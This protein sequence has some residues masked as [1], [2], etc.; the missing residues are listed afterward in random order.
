MEENQKKMVKLIS[1]IAL[2]AIVVIVAFTTVAP[3]EGG[4]RFAGTFWSLVPPLVAII[5]ALITREV[6][7]S[8]FVGIAIGALFLADGDLLQTLQN[9]VGFTYDDA[10]GCFVT[11]DYGFLN[12]LSSTWNAGILMFLVVLG[13][14]GVIMYA[15]GG[16]RAF[17][18]WAEKHIKGPRSAQAYTFG[19]G[20]I[21]FIDDYF[22]CL[23][24]GTTMRS[25]TDK[26]K[27]SRAKLAY[28]IDSTAAPICII[29]PISSW[30]AAV[31]GSLP[32]TFTAMSGFDIFLQS[33]PYNFYAIF[34]IV[35]I[36]V[37]IAF[38]FDFGPM[39]IHE[40]NAREKG[41]LYTTSERPY[42]GVEE[43]EFNPKGKLIDL[44]IPI[45]LF[46]VPISIVMMIYTGGFFKGVPFVDAFSGADASLA[47]A[48][49]SVLSLLLTVGYFSIRRTVAFKDMMLSLPKGFSNMVYA[50]LILV[51][52]WTMCSITSGLDSDTFVKEALAGTTIQNLLP[53]AFM[54]VACFIAFSTGTSWGTFGILIPIVCA[55]F[56]EGG[57][58]FVV[59]VSASLAGAVFGDHCSPVSDTTIL[60][61]A[62]AQCD[63]LNHVSTQAP[64]AIL[65]AAIS[66]VFFL[67]AGFWQSYIV[68]AIG[69]VAMVAILFLIKK[70]ED[71]G[72]SF[73][74][75]SK[76][77]R[78]V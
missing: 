24:V 51:F 30:A 56:P 61:S 22:N 14:I 60:S 47:L 49:S 27:I 73:N 34:T 2:V 65:V 75:G 17:G 9:I 78:N 26:Y 35:M 77:G 11:A 58:L 50:I 69:I 18:T 31:T 48:A 4:C 8:L 21:L 67:I 6:F 40:K 37:L 15:G 5:L 32:D 71:N 28:I 25:I 1:I 45:F 63:H 52:A 39:R 64:Y 20:I 46:L 72:K 68:T 12:V 57:A 74:F 44:L 43:E 62:G 23:T 13:I 7:P 16:V 19:L 42:A 54:L 33:I 76:I 55:V 3:I 10:E 53:V 66:A 59:G 36:I 29:A 70:M 41:D 38:N